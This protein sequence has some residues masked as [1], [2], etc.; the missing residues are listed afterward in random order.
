[1]TL[2]QI[3]IS[4][5]GIISFMYIVTVIMGFIGIKFHFYGYYLLWVIALFLFWLIIPKE[6]N[7]FV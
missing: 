3:G 2:K 6:K 5:F 4:L 7:Y 1:M